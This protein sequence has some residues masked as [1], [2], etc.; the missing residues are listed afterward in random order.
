LLAGVKKGS[1]SSIKIKRRR[2]LAVDA[3]L[4]A[5][6]A[7]AA[8]FENRL[9]PLLPYCPLYRFTGFRCP[10]CGGTRAFR[11][12]LRLNFLRAASY[13]PF[14][15][16]LG[17]WCFFVLAAYHLKL[18]ASLR[19]YD[20]ISK[21]VMLCCICIAALLFFIVRNLPFYPFL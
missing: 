3:L 19:L 10:A 7:V 21:H 15:L 11:E 5:A 1:I 20:R 14:L 4:A 12:L 13:N 6:V 8:A 2:L 9:A 18:F 16:L 17:L